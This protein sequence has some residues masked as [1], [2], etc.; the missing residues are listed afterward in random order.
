ML[1]ATQLVL[2]GGIHVRLGSQVRVFHFLEKLLVYALTLREILLDHGLNSHPVK[3]FL[4]LIHFALLQIHVDLV[5]THLQWLIVSLTAARAAPFVMS[6]INMFPASDRVECFLA[7][8][9]VYCL[10]LGSPHLLS[11]IE[12]FIHNA[13]ATGLTCIQVQDLV[14][15]WRTH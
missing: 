7:F 2:N 9:L 3:M 15:G 14:R 10:L 4:L 1:C 12:H 8:E 5:A 13:S 6:E 11:P